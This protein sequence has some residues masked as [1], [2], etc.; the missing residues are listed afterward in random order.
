MRT[1][2]RTVLGVAA[3][4]GLGATPAR[5]Q[6]PT[7]DSRWLAYI[8]CWEPVEGAKS[9]VCVVPAGPSAVDLVTI[10]KGEVGTR[11]HIAAT[12]ERVATTRGDCT[13]WHSAAWS[14]LGQHLY[15]RTQDTCPGQSARGGTG[16]IAMTGDG[17]WLYIQSMTLGGQTGVHVQRYREAPSEIV[18][19][20]EIAAALRLDVSS[21]IQSRAAAS[22][23]LSLDDV[24][25]ASRQVDAPVLE[26]WLVERDEPFT[27]DAK[28]LITLADAGVPSRV[29]DLMVALSYPKVFAINAMSRE[30]ERRVV[31]SGA[32]VYTGNDNAIARGYPLCSPLF[33]S[34]PLLLDDFMYPYAY[35][36]SSYD[37]TGLGGYRY[38]Y[39]W[40]PGAYPVTI[41]YSPPGGGSPPHGRV[42]NGQ[43]YKQGSSGSSGNAIPRTSEPTWAT[44]SGSSS[45]SSSPSSSS[46]GSASG[47]G[48]RT[49]HHRP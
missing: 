24:I 42:V 14:T 45:G 17:Q 15:L 43:G 12:G 7:V 6:N 35:P 30:G 41:V 26:T 39:G 34:Y 32:G 11:E 21:A 40:Y 28:R 4:I 10:A 44:P 13:G 47:A 1:R 36:Y 48:E 49:A 22:A 38:G 20:D 37:C 19:P 46:S 8:G 33:I 25:D 3:C 23:P 27:L 18:L 31:P 2:I 16:V 9:P 5:G 29:I